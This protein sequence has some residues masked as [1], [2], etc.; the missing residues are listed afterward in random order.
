MRT[1]HA[2]V[3]CTVASVSAFGLDNPCFQQQGRLR[4]YVQQRNLLPKKRTMGCI[5]IHGTRDCGVLTG[6][7]NENDAGQDLPT[8]SVEDVDELDEETL[9]EIEAGQPSEWMVM[10]EVS[11]LRQTQRLIA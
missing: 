2:V 7:R 11:M 5:F 10:K 6:T 1:I 9:E 8:L 4:S 3:V